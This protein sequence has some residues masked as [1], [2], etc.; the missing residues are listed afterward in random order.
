MSTANSRDFSTSVAS[1]TEF[2]EPTML[3]PRNVTPLGSRTLKTSPGLPGLATTFKTPGNTGRTNPGSSNLLQLGFN[4][5]TPTGSRTSPGLLGSTGP[6]KT[7]IRTNDGSPFRQGL[8]SSGVSDPGSSRRSSAPFGGDSFFD[9]DAW[10]A[11]DDMASPA[12]VSRTPSFG[13][14][15]VATFGKASPAAS[16]SMHSR[17]NA[18]SNKAPVDDSLMIQGNLLY[19]ISEMVLNERYYFIFEEASI[20]QRSHGHT[21]LLHTICAIPG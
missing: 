17:L 15:S 5:M 13:T 1:S 16:G 14:S 6:F 9:D 11:L 20:V 12:A 18:S 8:N 10:S 4:S 2:K 21:H 19:L 3:P 7:P